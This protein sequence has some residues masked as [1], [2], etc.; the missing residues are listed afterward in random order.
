MMINTY[1]SFAQNYINS[2]QSGQKFTS[3]MSNPLL[4]STPEALTF[5]LIGSLDSNNSR[6]LNQSESGLGNSDFSQVD[7]NSDG[8]I[9][10]TELINRV[11]TERNTYVE[12]LFINSQYSAFG[13]LSEDG[14]MQILGMDSESSALMESALKTQERSDFQKITAYNQNLLYH[15]QLSPAQPAEAESFADPSANL[16]E[17]I[18]PLQALEMQATLP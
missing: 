14:F 7:K 2:R 15:T 5:E 18:A 4:L 10:F 1:N 3:N 17:I 16:Y 6:S 9:G 12:L 11:E 13:T 8:E